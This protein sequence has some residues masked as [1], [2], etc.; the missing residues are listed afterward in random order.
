MKGHDMARALFGHMSNSAD[1]A[2]IEE[3]ARLKRRI[4]LLEREI[5]DL[6]TAAASAELFDELHR[7]TSSES[8]L[9]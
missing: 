7:I 3:N 6:K 9:A 4:T 8:A 5:S 2:L 1:L